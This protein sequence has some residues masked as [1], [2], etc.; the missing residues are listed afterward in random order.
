MNIY[1]FLKDYKWIK[2]KYENE[3]KIIEKINKERL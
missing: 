3:N 1:K 2:F